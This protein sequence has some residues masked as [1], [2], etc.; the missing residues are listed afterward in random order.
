MKVIALLGSTKKGGNTELLLS[1]DE[2]GAV[3]RHPTALIDAYEA[4]KALVKGDNS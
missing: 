1:M 4:G 2:N 3:L